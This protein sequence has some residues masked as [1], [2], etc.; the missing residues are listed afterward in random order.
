MSIE[1]ARLEREVEDLKKKLAMSD[2]AVASFKVLFDQAQDILN[3][4]IGALGGVSDA[5][6]SAKLREAVTKLLGVYGEKVQG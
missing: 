4:L 2:A 5:E 1:K 3:R 6:T